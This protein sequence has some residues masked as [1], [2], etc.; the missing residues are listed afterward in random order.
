MQKSTIELTDDVAA[1]LELGVALGQSQTFSLV[2]GRC[3]AAQAATLLRLRQ[4]KKYLRCSANWREFCTN[5]LKISG[6]EA[7]R[8]IRLWEEFG[9]SY[10][11]LAQLIRISPEGY[12]A[13][14]PAVKEGAL[15]HDGETIEFD[16]ENSRKLAEAVAELKGAQTATKPANRPARKSPP[17]LEPHDRIADLDRRCTGIIMEFQEISRKERSGENWLLLT[18]ALLRVREELSRIERENGL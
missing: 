4:E 7:D 2:A 9:A 8:I 6:S 3:S 12:R 18:R 13:I 14:E 17:H 11:E 10:F 1:V 15:Q 16:P 5:Y